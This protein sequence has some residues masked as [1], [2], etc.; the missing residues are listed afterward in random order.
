MTKGIGGQTS[1]GTRDAEGVLVITGMHRSGTSLVASLLERG[2]LHLGENLLPA[3]QGNPRG[4]YEDLDFYRFHSEALENRQQSLSIVEDFLFE[5]TSSERCRAKAIVAARRHR[6]FWGWKDPRTA[7]FLDFWNEQLPDARFLFLFRHP[8]DVLL[9]LVRRGDVNCLGLTEGLDAWSRYNE[10]ILRFFIDHRE[11]S[12]LCHI[13]SVLESTDSF[14]TLLRDRLGFEIERSYLEAVYHPKELR[15]I[16]LAPEVADAFRSIHPSVARLYDHLNESADLGY[17]G[18]R[19]HRQSRG[20][21]GAWV[22]DL[23][24]KK[25]PGLRR[26]L[27]SALIALVE[28]ESLENLYRVFGGY[29]LERNRG[30]AWLKERVEG[31]EALL[32]RSGESNEKLRA[33]TEE[34]ERGRDW[35]EEQ[36]R[37][38]E[39]TLAQQRE[40]LEGQL[41]EERRHR[42][43]GYAELESWIRELERGRDWLLE[44]RTHFEEDQRRRAEQNEE[45]RR[46]VA[47]LEQGRDWLQQQ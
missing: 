42:E 29:Q 20:K 26:G 34:L 7:L 3:D 13:R 6:G 35:L 41:D 32:K 22:K 23:E 8:L 37:N 38:L 44:Q 16:E 33:W 2:G 11:R 43:R 4:Y 25:S 10:K 24:T 18:T 1:G 47:E 9:S 30:L 21:F 17:V 40:N 45:L 19:N 28:P 31:M 15:H 27:T 39:L 5:P 12:L 14:A 46:W 36:R